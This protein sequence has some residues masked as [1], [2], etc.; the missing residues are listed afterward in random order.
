MKRNET[1]YEIA[2][3]YKENNIS[4]HITL[5]SGKWLNGFISNVNEDFKDRLIL[6][7]DKFGEMLVLFDRIIDDGIEPREKKESR[8]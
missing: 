2:R 7:E 6:Y 4:V 8:E 1:L 3:Y 5:I